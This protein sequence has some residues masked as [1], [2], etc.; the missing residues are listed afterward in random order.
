MH[1]E[2]AAD[3]AGGR[4]FG[5][6]RAVDVASLDVEAVEPQ[7]HGVLAVNVGRNVDRYTLVDVILD[8]AI[9]QLVSDDEGQR[10]G[11]KSGSLR[12]WHAWT[13]L[14]EGLAGA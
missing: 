3:A 5:V 4:Q 10:L 11:G 7:Q 9:P 13:L 14:L 12:L 8:V 1:A 6:F 2:A